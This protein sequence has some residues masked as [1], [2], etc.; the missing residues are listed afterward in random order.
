M[1]RHPGE[2]VNGGF[3]F[4]VCNQE[5]LPSLDLY[6]SALDSKK[7]YLEKKVRKKNL[8][9]CLVFFFLVTHFFFKAK[10]KRL[11]RDLEAAEQRCNELSV[12]ITDILSKTPKIPKTFKTPK[13]LSSVPLA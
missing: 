4:F 1:V 5:T 8:F 11:K 10:V 6:L 3:C 12:D 13:K 7:I 9:R 2:T